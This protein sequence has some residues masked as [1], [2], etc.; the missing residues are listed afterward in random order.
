[1]WEILFYHHVLEVLYIEL[2]IL[3]R[4]RRELKEFYVTVQKN[5]LCLVEEWKGKKFIIQIHTL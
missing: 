1:M 5:I 4:L 3:L 2:D